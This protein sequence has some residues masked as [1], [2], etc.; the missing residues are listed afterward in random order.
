MKANSILIC[1]D[2]AN[3]REILKDFFME[4]GFFVFTSGSG[5]ESLELIE[6]ETPDIVVS[7]FKLPGIS[8]IELVEEIHR[9]DSNIP[10]IVITAF[11]SIPNAVEAMRKG[12]YDYLTKPIDYDLLF[13]VVSRALEQRMI[14]EQ[15]T[16]LIKELKSVY[17]VQNL[18]GNSLEMKTLYQLINTV[19]KS[20]TNV[21]I[22]GESGTGK[23]LIARTIHYTSARRD[24]PLA[25]VDCAALPDNLLESELFGYEKGSFTGADTRK[26]G[27]IELSQGGTL[28]LDEIGEMSLPLQAKLLRL[29]QER[30]FHRIGGLS[31]VEVDFRLIAA[32]NKNLKEEVKS[33]RF[34]SDLYYRLNVVTLQAP[35]LGDRKDDI[36]LLTNHFIE[37][38]C[39]RDGL[40]RKNISDEVISELISSD[41]PGNVRELE[42]C[43]E[44]MILFT[45]DNT[46][47]KSFLANCLPVYKQNTVLPDILDLNKLEKETVSRALEQS[48]WNKVEA[49]KLLNI[50]RKALYNKINKF[51]IKKK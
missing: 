31:P 38:I 1:D 21:L 46:I 49:A 25:I 6:K 12:A 44:R 35:S 45:E 8:G 37:K 26:K 4:K 36:P 28:F 47:Q 3:I 16:A 22:Q 7:D 23:E 30:K 51:E 42:N 9:R 29:I 48:N 40:M 33:Q 11:G 24:K 17:G 13:F 43:V 32:T 19:A 20:A 41:W 2:K 27:R 5:E 15:N 18:I 39:K 50:G 34:R 10:V 14:Y